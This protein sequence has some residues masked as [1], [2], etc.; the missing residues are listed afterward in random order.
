MRI[1]ISGSHSLGKS[2][3][4]HDWVTAHPEYRRE[5][6]PYRALGLHGPYE[7]RFRDESTRLQNGLQL[8]YCIARVQRHA[9]SDATV[10]FDRAPVDYLAYSQ[11]T[12]ECG[13]TDIDDA[14]VE[15]MVPAVR[16]SLDRLDILAFVPESKE[17]PVEMEDDGIRPVDL[18]YRDRVDAIFKQIYREGRFGVMPA[19]DPPLLVELSGPRSRRLEQLGAALARRERG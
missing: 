5:E 11:F 10:I 1:A 7:I 4:V 8:Y 19:D 16:E 17:W 14:F 3:V 2:T 15:S 12:A 6:E 18:G 13:T 9:T